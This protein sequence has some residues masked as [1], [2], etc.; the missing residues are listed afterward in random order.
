[1]FSGRLRVGARAICMGF[2]VRAPPLVRTPAASSGAGWSR[3]EERIPEQF[4]Y[5]RGWGGNRAKTPAGNQ[6]HYRSLADGRPGDDG[7]LVRR[8]PARGLFGSGVTSRV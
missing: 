1:M 7:L 4:Y 2:M 5:P 8:D 6:R 3:A